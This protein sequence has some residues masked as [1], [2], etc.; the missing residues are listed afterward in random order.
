MLRSLS[1]YLKEDS[2]VVKKDYWALALYTGVPVFCIGFITLIFIYIYPR[3]IHIAVVDFDNT[4]ASRSII[5]N[6]NATPNVTVAAHLTSMRELKAGLDSGKY[7]GGLVVPRGLEG[8]ATQGISTP[9]PFYYNAQFLLIGK[10]LF[11]SYLNAVGYSNVVL[12]LPRYLVA[13]KDVALASSEVMPIMNDITALFN[14]SQSYANYLLI[15]ILPCVIQLFFA[16]TL[17]DAL[18]RAML[19]DYTKSALTLSLAPLVTNIFISYL[20]FLFVMSIFYLLD[21]PFNGSFAILSLAYIMMLVALGSVVCFLK[22]VLVE[23]A[24]TMS[25]IA[26][27]TAPSFAFVSITYPNNNMQPFGDI[28]SHAL[29]IYYFLQVYVEQA[30]YG[31]GVKSLHMIAYMV[32]FVIFIFFTM[33]IFSWRIRHNK[34]DEM[35]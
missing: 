25:F 12:S 28:V 4:A 23:N 20:Y 24:R 21:F 19:R 11:S 29:P 13:K 17:C 5:Y 9:I 16:I 33:Q 3:D 2:Q 14:K 30:K 10:T 35:I 7:F 32:P 34:L 8:N 31:I 27:Y 15:A 26:A 6:I 18:D 1:N 22:S